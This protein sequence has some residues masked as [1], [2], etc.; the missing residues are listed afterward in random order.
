MSSH[1]EGG[2]VDGKDASKLNVESVKVWSIFLSSIWEFEMLFF[3]KIIIFSVFS[4][5]FFG[6]FRPPGYKTTEVGP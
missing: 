6:L 5:F 4:H 3:L 2:L 1:L